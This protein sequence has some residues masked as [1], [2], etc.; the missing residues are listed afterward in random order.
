ME[1]RF[2]YGVAGVPVAAGSTAAT[3]D[4]QL[5][6]SNERPSARPRR[7]RLTC[8]AVDAGMLG[9]ALTLG[10]QVSPAGTSGQ[11]LG[12]SG[13][14]AVLALL[15]FALRGAYGPRPDLRLLESIFSVVAVGATA[16]VV[17]VTVRV[18]LGDDRVVGVQTA[19]F[20]LL[21]TALLGAGRAALLQSEGRAKRRGRTACPTLIVGAGQIGRLT[22]KRLQ[23]EPQLGLHP[24]GFL[25]KEPLETHGGS[26]S[27]PV[28]GASW[29]LE[30]VVSEHR[31]GHVVVTFSTAP[32]H[33][34][35]DLV[36]RCRELCIEVSVIPRLFEVQGER[37][38]VARL[39]ALPLITTRFVNPRGWQF[40]VK[41]AV[42]R[43]VAGLALVVSLP[44][45]ALAMITVRLTIGSPV[46][47]RQ[48][49]IGGDGHEFE[50]LK[51][52]TMKGTPAEDGEADLE[53]A[54]RQLAG[55][56]VASPAPV[57]SNG[58]SEVQA[59]DR[60][61]SLGRILRRFSLDEIPQLW[62][63]V[64][65]E[66]SLVGPRPE[67]VGYVRRFEHS[68]DRYGDRHRVRSGI[69]G[70]AQVNGLRGRTSLN[71]RVEWDNYYIE[72][73]SPWLD[74]KIIAMTVACVLRGKHEEQPL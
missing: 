13:A 18:L 23:D 43:V 73:W 28:L 50:M 67:R 44:L 1:D 37:V 41:Y 38:S 25:D 29:D 56:G 71:D 27:P 11:Y 57:A 49:R 39:G 5:S 26:A 65:G 72:S 20:W 53:W 2:M 46:V 24:I 70:W 17:L 59:G 48:R 32:H 69:T 10:V 62:N 74:F 19:H 36:R 45:I 14:L 40:R 9:A 55:N 8:L 63:V 12:W 33:V 35:L 15:L 7:H 68:I 61:T 66:M 51:L 6:A 60:S 58:G 30:K 52:R 47:F 42:E 34:L 4:E 31:V 3:L 21:A 64:R 54:A 22:A 16:A